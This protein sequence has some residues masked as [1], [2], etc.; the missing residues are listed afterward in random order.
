M[1]YKDRI[2]QQAVYFF[3]YFLK[4]GCISHHLIRNAGHGLNIIG[5]GLSG[6]NQGFILLNDR[7]AIKNMNSDL[8]DS[9]GSCVGACGFYVDDGVDWL[10]S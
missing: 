1:G 2:L 10:I 4:P 8:R 3:G 6:V 9:V 5:N 7:I